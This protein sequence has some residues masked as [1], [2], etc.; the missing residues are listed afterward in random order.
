LQ[1][2]TEPFGA[3][4]DGFFCFY[5]LINYGGFNMRKERERKTE[6]RHLA[7][8]A[9]LADEVA[10]G[11]YPS[12]TKDLLWIK[13][14]NEGLRILPHDP[15]LIDKTISKIEALKVL[16]KLDRDYWE[17]FIVFDIIPNKYAEV[18]K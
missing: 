3:N 10:E 7:L 2:L 8:Q 5:I 11:L 12:L 1:L 6:R 17:L 18:L 4:P 13:A 9:E 16:M 15:V 14:Q